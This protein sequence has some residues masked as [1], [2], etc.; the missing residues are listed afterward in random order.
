MSHQLHNYAH[1]QW[2]VGTGKLTE[3]HDASIGEHIG[4]TSSCGLAFGH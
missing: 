1:G 2:I 4:T 3:L